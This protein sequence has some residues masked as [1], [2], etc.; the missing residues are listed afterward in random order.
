VCVKWV[1]E[2]ACVFTCMPVHVCAFLIMC[3]FDRVCVWCVGVS[4][5]LC[6]CMSVRACV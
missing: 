6:V 1:L 3:V 2:Y 5:Y 4:V